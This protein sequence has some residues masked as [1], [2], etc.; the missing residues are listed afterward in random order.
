MNIA[1]KVGLAAVALAGCT[2]AAV[3]RLTNYGESGR[4]TCYAGAYVVFDDFSTGRIE[5]HGSSDGFFFVSN[6]TQRLTE[7]TGDCVV[8]YG[9][10][11]PADFQPIRL[12]R[13]HVSTTGAAS[14][15]APARDLLDASDATSN[16]VPGGKPD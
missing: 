5:K 16:T 2:D 11:Y 14:P 13:A 6:S 7:T 12:Q 8:D 15:A 10:P 9:A 3:A 1:V 4:V